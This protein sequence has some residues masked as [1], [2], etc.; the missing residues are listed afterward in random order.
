MRK[1]IA[2]ALCIAAFLVSSSET[3]AESYSE[4]FECTF[5]RGLAN[6]PTPTRVVFSV[7]ESRRSA[8]LHQVDIPGIVTSRLAASIDRDS[9]RL[10]SISWP[11]DTYLFAA[12][13]RPTHAGDNRSRIRDLRLTEFSLFLDRGNKQAIVRSKVADGASLIGNAKGKCVPVD[14]NN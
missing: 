3:V 9:F 5:D 13:N 11:G 2:S 12:T 1:K 10:I 7:D 4:S 14:L 6:L 8:L